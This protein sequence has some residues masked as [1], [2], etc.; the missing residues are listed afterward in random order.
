MFQLYFS[1]ENDLKV[2]QMSEKYQ[3]P[4]KINNNSDKKN[5]KNYEIITTKALG[6]S[7]DSPASPWK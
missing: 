4:Y 7:I 2:D 6:A 5:K 1:L 3:V